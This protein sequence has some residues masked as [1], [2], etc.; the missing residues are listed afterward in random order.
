MHEKVRHTVQKR[1]T[2]SHVT[3]A[4]E[5]VVEA[6][7]QTNQLDILLEL[8]AHR[9]ALIATVRSRTDFDFGVLLDQL[10]QDVNAIDA[11]V[12]RLRGRVED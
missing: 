8:K 1:G 4:I 6:Y 2:I 11:G 12:R 10:E 3:S 5:Q 9:E 7:V